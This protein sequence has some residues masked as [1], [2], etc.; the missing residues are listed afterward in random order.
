MRAEAEFAPLWA[1][2]PGRTISDLMKSR[3]I[4]S[5][6]LARSVDMS[7]DDFGNLLKGTYVL[8]APIAKRLE[9][10]LGAS[11]GFWLCRE[12]QYREQLAQLTGGVDPDNDEYQAW[13]K[14]L[15]LRQM[16]ELGWVEPTK[17]KREKLRR[18]LAFFDV[19]NLDAWRRTYSDVKGA[20]A[21]RTSET[22]A[23][24]EV[25]TA[26]WLRQGELEA[27][28]IEC[29]P[30][31]PS[32]F[33]N[34]FPKIRSLT[35][36]SHPAEFLPKLQ[37]LCAEAGVAVVVVKAPKGCRASGATF[38][39]GPDKAV[40]LLSVRYLSDDQFWFS[41]FH[42]AGHLILHW[43]ADLLILETSD[44]PMSPQEDEANKFATE[45]LIPPGLQARL[46]AA[47]K[48]LKGI[49]RLAR[50][51]GVSY[52]IVVGQMQFRGLVSQRNYNSLKN[53]YKWNGD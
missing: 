32:L 46:P 20:A 11:A 53:R 31:N 13:L 38:F 50:D 4:A 10:E 48:S 40:L 34:Q 2:P 22:F 26:A 36:I 8:T 35:T 24:D 17:D 29:K 49:M 23:E 9:A 33:A 39:G 47:S 52:G 6:H 30:W 18:C 15:P 7:D 3:G 28:K 41:F 43:D 25:S 14:S 42:E 1:V 19:P 12:E 5:T 27:D 16:Q 51:A 21:F 37:N 44:G 45:Q